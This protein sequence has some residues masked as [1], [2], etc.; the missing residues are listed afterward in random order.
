MPMGWVRAWRAERDERQAQ[1]ERFDACKFRRTFKTQLRQTRSASGRVLTELDYDSILTLPNG[2]ED[3]WTA[4]SIDGQDG[5]VNSDHIVEIAY[6]TAK[7]SDEDENLETGDYILPIKA[8]KNLTARGNATRTKLLWGDI[9]QIFARYEKAAYVRCRSWYGYVDIYRL[10]PEPIL[11]VYVIDVGQ[12]DGVLVRDINGRHILIDGGLSR[13]FQQSGKNAA[14][15]VDW[16]FFSDYG[17]HAVHLDAMVASH[18]DAD[19][20]GGLNDLIA[21]SRSA[22]DQ[23]DVDSVTV[24]NFYHAGL[25]YWKVRSEDRVNYPDQLSASVTKWLG[26][27]IDWAGDTPQ[28]NGS[29][30]HGQ[31]DRR[32]DPKIKP[33][34]LGDKEDFD[35]AV[36]RNASMPLGGS[37]GTFLRAIAKP[38]IGLEEVYRLG[39]TQEE[40]GSAVFM[41]G[42]HTTETENPI[43][44]L[45]PVTVKHDNEPALPDFESNS[46]NTNGHSV[47]LRI[48]YGKARIL[49]TGD[50]NKN[51]MDWL[52]HAHNE[53][54]I[55]QSDVAKGCHHG[56]S[57]ISHAFLQEINAGATVISSGDAEGHAHPR[58]EV[59]GASSMTGFQDV[60]DDKMITPLL[61]MTEI[62]RSFSVGKIKQVRFFNYPDGDGSGDDGA[63]FGQPFTDSDDDPEL[64]RWSEA[65]EAANASAKVEFTYQ[66]ELWTTKSGEL[67]LKGARIMRKVHYGL[68]NIRT[69]GN[70]IMCATMKESG[71]GWTVHVFPARDHAANAQS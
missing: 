55:F 28:P 46:Q 1:A 7:P 70:M 27:S 54:K 36:S 39:V 3:N 23:L 19:H 35:E 64:A 25:S 17:H 31:A 56:S 69:D 37:W 30:V 62:E 11:E 68:V 18:C 2:I 24:Q 4:A 47:L 26:P 66:K 6:V 22:K 40:N 52:R 43:R 57:D 16:K 12:G 10:S 48:D 60:R 53:E 61:Y 14:D 5:F 29:F 9:V 63:L 32:V 49:M 71:S 58:P 38:K 50:L 45:G 67:D 34:L 65:Y 42:W 51:S 15:F 33:W 59:A 21:T 13:R 41:P 8:K 20:F 44:V